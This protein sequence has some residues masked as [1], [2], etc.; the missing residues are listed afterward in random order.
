MLD[1]IWDEFAHSGRIEDYLNY[2]NYKNK[3]AEYNEYFDERI[4]HKRADDRGE[5]QTG[6][7]FNG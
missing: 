3:K 7:S 2:V 5:R 1:K 4:G 6:N